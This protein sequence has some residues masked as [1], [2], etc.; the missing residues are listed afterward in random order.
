VK[1]KR[2]LPEVAAR[3]AVHDTAIQIRGLN[4]K[5][6]G[7]PGTPP[8]RVLD[9]VNFDIRRGEFVCIVGPSG[10]GKST[11]LNVVAGFVRPG[12][13]AAQIE[14]DVRVER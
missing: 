11:L 8:V 6:P 5:F 13:G 10:C 4:L 3:D 1:T 14:G 2:S 7:Q 12:K 9:D